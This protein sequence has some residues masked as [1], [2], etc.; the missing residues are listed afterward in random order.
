MS[1][2]QYKPAIKSESTPVHS[3]GGNATYA[4]I[5]AYIKEKYGLCVSSLY[6][7]QIKE[8]FGIEK[9]LNYRKGDGKSR[10]PLCPAEKE[11]AIT[12]AFIYFGMI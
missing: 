3:R 9:R 7:A 4:E 8:N 10:V 11:K 5:K 2:I 12:E 6:I 1:N